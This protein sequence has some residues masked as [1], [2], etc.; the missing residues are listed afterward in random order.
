MAAPL[1]NQDGGNIL[2]SG[3]FI[4]YLLPYLLISLNTLRKEKEIPLFKKHLKL[5]QLYIFSSH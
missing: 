5:Q 2:Y 3:I 4:Y 1:K